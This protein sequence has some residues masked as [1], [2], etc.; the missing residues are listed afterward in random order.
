MGVG[1]QTID[2]LLAALA[3]KKPTPGGGAV[4]PIVG[5]LGAALARMVIAYSVGRKSLAEHEAMLTDADGRLARASAVLLA[6]ADADAE[7]YSLLN[8]AMKLPKDDPARAARVAA[9]ARDAIAPPRA[10]MATG[11]DLLRLFEELAPKTNKMLAS[12]LRIAAILAESLVRCAAEN[13]R[14]NLPLLGDDAVAGELAVECDRS[15]LQAVERSAV[16]VGSAA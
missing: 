13:V 5:A 12:D 6:L 3:S 9:A 16:I 15:C 7:A 1:D 10:A 4:A 2:T 14:V 11:I 8:E